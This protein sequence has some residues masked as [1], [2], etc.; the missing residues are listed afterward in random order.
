MTKTSPPRPETVRAMAEEVARDVQYRPVETTGA[1]RAAKCIA[2]LLSD[3]YSDERRALIGDRAS[4]EL[5]PGTVS[6]RPSPRAA[7]TAPR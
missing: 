6:A 3:A 1:A 4:H 2:E 5:R 7:S